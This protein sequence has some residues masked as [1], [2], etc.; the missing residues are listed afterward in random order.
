M[1]ER[2]KPDF[3]SYV[4]IDIETTGL[5]AD[6]RIVEI[7]AAKVIDGAVT[8][9]LSQLVNPSIKMNPSASAVNGITDQMLT[10]KPPIG[11]VIKHF[12]EFVGGH[13]LVGHNI[14]QFDLRYILKAAASEGLR[15]E[16][17]YFD[18][19]LFARNMQYKF[20]WQKASLEYLM[21]ALGLK[22]NDAHRA[23]GDALD[24]AQLYSKLQSMTAQGYRAPSR[25]KA[26]TR[27]A[28]DSRWGNWDSH[29]HNQDEQIKRQIRA[30]PNDMNPVSV[31]R[32]ASTA[33]FGGTD[34]VHTACLTE[35]SCVD[36]RTRKLP[37]KH[38][39]RLASEL[40][41][42]KLNINISYSEIDNEVLK[43][44]RKLKAELRQNP[45]KAKI[46]DA[47][48]QSEVNLSQHLEQCVEPTEELIAVTSF[49]SKINAALSEKGKLK[50]QARSVTDI[51]LK[52]GYLELDAKGQRVASAK[53][54]LTGISTQEKQKETG[55]HYTQNLYNKTGQQLLLRYAI[56]ALQENLQ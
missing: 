51:L 29:I 26:L 43:N 47:S 32:A 4:A 2:M 17:S 25:S 20:G 56:I 10:G 39:Y 30:A 18:T 46:V 7:G 3:S 22:R 34:S 21:Q 11:S 36:F 38:I 8:D 27:N 14:K 12:A 6:A 31:D 50:L 42:Y 49:I 55:E 1:L 45:N 24:V 33:K 48:K 23:L 54:T 44:I 35:C 52:D 40:G 16:N 9:T 37:C 41:L 53:G 13:T 5:G 15:L 19:L 28:G